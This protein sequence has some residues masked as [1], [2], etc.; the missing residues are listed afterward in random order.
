M[1]LGSAPA[2]ACR[3]ARTASTTF[4]APSGMTI[5]D[6]TLTPPADLP[7]RRAGQRHPPAVRDLHARRHRVRR[8]GRLPARDP[9]PPARPGQLVRLS[10]DQRRRARS[11]VSRASFPALAGYTG[12]AT[13]L[14]IVVGCFN[15]SKNTPARPPAGGGD[16]APALG[17]ARGAQRPDARRPPRR[18]LRAA[19]R[20]APQRLRRRH[21][22]RQ[23]Q[24]RHPP[25]RDRRPQRRRR[26]SAARTTARARAPTPARPARRGCEKAVPEPQQRDRAPDQAARRPAHAEGPRHRRRRQ[27]HASRA[28]TWSTSP[29]RPTAAAQR[30][31]RR[32]TAARSART[33]RG[34]RKRTRPSATAAGAGQRP[35]AQLRRARRSP[36]RCSRSSRATAA[37]ART[38][39]GAGRRPR[40][41]RTALQA[42]RRAAASRLVQVAWASHIHD[43]SPQESAYLTLNARASSS[44]HATPRVGRRRPDAAASR[45]RCAASIPRAAC[46]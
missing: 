7:Q 35:A 33:S 41:A 37:R 31:R 4:T 29:R 38:S 24:R 9:R 44:L 36:A 30:Q 17:R 3:T 8:R 18:G 20:R 23:R 10:G 15:G 12:N 40:P 5:A 22:R 34:T 28:R 21:A 42:P 13:S 46:R 11:T 16:R 19:G 43:P 26:S 27:R 2:H 32:P 1:G 14:Q 39:S 25:G 45:H 6:F